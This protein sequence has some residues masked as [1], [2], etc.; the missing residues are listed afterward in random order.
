MI[1]AD[2]LA[3]IAGELLLVTGH[4]VDAATLLLGPPDLAAPVPELAMAVVADA[5]LGV[6]RGAGEAMGLARV[7][8]LD[9]VRAEGGAADHSG[10]GAGDIAVI[11]VRAD[12]DEVRLLELELLLEVLVVLRTSDVEHLLE[13]GAVFDRVG[14]H[15]RRRLELVSEI[16]TEGSLDLVLLYPDQPVQIGRRHVAPAGCHAVVL[17]D[18]FLRRVVV[19]HLRVHVHAERVVRLGT[20][21]VTF[22]VA[23]LTEDDHVVLGRVG[24]AR[25]R[26]LRS[27]RMGCRLG[28]IETHSASSGCKEKMKR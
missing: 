12:Q 11:V 10:A 18:P 3:T 4:R 19:P 21:I 9:R 7:L 22:T 17:E 1:P 25:D 8:R 27:R 13:G 2:R 20:R 6:H 15:V 28:A 5:L 23:G 16:E 24:D 14:D 26:R